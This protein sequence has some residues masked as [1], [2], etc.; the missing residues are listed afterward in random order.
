MLDL[1]PS[2]APADLPS[3]L[4]SLSAVAPLLDAMPGVVFFVKDA[5][6]GRFVLLNKAGEELLGLSR[7]DLIGKTDFDLFDPEDALRSEAFVADGAS[8]FGAQPGAQQQAQ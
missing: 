3:L 4:A 1:L 8:A 6:D 7:H 2:T 5:Q